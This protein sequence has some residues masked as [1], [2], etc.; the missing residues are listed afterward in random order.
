LE[1]VAV[2]PAILPTPT[3]PVEPIPPGSAGYAQ[4]PSA[5]ERREKAEKEASQSA[6]RLR[7]PVARPTTI[8]GRSA[9]AAS[10]SAESPWYYWALGVTT[11]LAL[12]LSARGL[13]PRSRARPAWLDL[14]PAAA[15]RRKQR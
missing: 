10:G 14:P 9:A 1:P 13:R 5:A 12:C 6:F 4:S 15:E 3:P 11:L 8:G 2:A 7:P